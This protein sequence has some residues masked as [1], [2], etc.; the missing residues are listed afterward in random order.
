MNILTHIN[1]SNLFDQLIVKWQ[2]MVKHHKFLES[3]VAN[4]PET[5]YIQFPII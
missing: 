5:K 4:S 1:V 2:K 3:K